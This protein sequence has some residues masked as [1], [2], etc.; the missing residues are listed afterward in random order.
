ML[1]KIR[2]IRLVKPLN[3]LEL[4]NIMSEAHIILTDSGGIQEEAP[5]FGKP[6]LILREKTER[7][8]A[9]KFKTARL[10]GT[11]TGR[12]VGETEKLLAS[13]T[14]YRKLVAKKNPFG[15]GK[16]AQRICMFLL[17]RYGLCGRKPKAFR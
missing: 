1:S 11:E 9:I 7:P 4:I 12:I 13:A 17:H 3:Y 5:A 15:D 8:E 16:A 6:V 14:E 2:N 10:V